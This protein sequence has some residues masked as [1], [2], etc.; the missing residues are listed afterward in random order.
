MTPLHPYVKKKIINTLNTH[1]TRKVSVYFNVYD[2]IDASSYG[3]T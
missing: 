2:L 3:F 1:Q